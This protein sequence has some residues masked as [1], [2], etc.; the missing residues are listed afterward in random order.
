M[1]HSASTSETDRQY[2][3]LSVLMPV[4]NEARTLRTIVSRVLAAPIAELGLD[5]EL[6]AVDDGSKDRSREILA[7]LAEGD[8]RIRVF[9]QHRNYGKGA[10]IRRAI[11]ECT[12]DI[13]IVQDSD[14][15]Y[16]PADYPRMLRPILEGNADA[17]FGSRFAAS[18]QRRV[19]LFWHS[20]ANRFL[21]TVTNMLNDIN[22]TDM[23]TC[24]KAVRTDILKRIP[25]K[26]DRFGIEPELTTR[27]AQWNARIYEVSISYH[28]RSYAEGKNITWKDGVQALWLLFKFRFFDK[29]FTTHDGYYMLE[30][31]RRARGYN[32]W[33]LSQFESH[34]GS[35]VLEAG[36]GIGNFTEQLLDRERLIC[37][38]LDP[39]YAEIADRRYAHLENVTA[40]QLDPSLADDVAPVAL[41]RPDTVIAM[42]VVEHVGDD[43]A[44][45][46]SYHDVLQ[47]GG[48]VVVLAPAH[49]WLFTEYDRRLGHFR[50][51]TRATLSERLKAAGFEVVHTQQ[52]NR[53]G[54][55]GWWA[56]GKLGRKQFTPGQMKL[57]HR[58]L[59]IAKIV[60]KI[61]SLPGL[62][63]I[64]IGRKPARSPQ[65]A[66]P[67]SEEQ[68]ETSSQVEAK[69]Q[70]EPVARA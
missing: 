62:S 36:C 34:V 2:R 49:D 24:Y 25:L 40:S 33:L 13:A 1:T 19:L 4:Y 70:H 23:E 69:P 39:Y 20:V 68:A 38:D 52:F 46:K 42:N 53:L 47:P 30:S 8:Q 7:E 44:V 21:T 41:E 66:P 64:A 9:H 55:L 56:S 10:A 12:G 48:T 58:L 31:V 11:D 14:L 17:V 5:L 3:K 63:V 6:I 16:D 50:R 60:E 27:L 67:A 43:E 51:Y 61:D 29:R 18:E 15:E 45:L 28:G 22:L 59:P 26:S 32:R 65:A 37:T 57:F 35:R 54:V